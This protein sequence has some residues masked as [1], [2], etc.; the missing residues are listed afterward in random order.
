MLASSP[1][2]KKEKPSSQGGGFFRLV[3]IVDFSDSDPNRKVQLLAAIVMHSR[4]WIEVGSM[5]DG[6]VVTTG[7]ET[8][9]GSWS[10]LAT[11]KL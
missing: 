9:I 6:N 11:Q 1:I 7:S 5:V 8:A 10:M 2:V 3:L 4:V